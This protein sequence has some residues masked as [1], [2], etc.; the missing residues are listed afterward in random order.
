MKYDSFL[1]HA[2]VTDAETMRLLNWISAIPLDRLGAIKTA[3]DIIIK[4]GISKNA[5]GGPPDAYVA[6]LEAIRAANAAKAAT[7]AAT[8]TTT[9]AASTA[10]KKFSLFKILSTVGLADL[11]SQLAL[12]VGD[13]TLLSGIRKAVS[14]LAEKLQLEENKAGL[15]GGLSSGALLGYLYALYTKDRPTLSNVALGALLGGVGG[16]GLSALSNKN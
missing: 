10:A 6:K 13:A 14:D 9:E 8:K 11:A 5:I 1:P 12:W 7:E 15:I 3:E 2:V 16:Y 4:F